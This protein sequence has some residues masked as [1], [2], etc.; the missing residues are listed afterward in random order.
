MREHLLKEADIES[1]MDKALENK[2][3]VFFLQPKFNVN[4]EKILGAEALVRWIDSQQQMI[5]PNDFIP[6]FEKNGFILKLEGVIF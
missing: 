3:F 2:E 4:G 6:L 5:M 1:K